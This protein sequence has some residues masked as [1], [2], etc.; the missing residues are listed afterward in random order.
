MRVPLTPD[1][2]WISYTTEDKVHLAGWIE[3]YGA[4]SNRLYINRGI[5][6]SVAPMRFN[7]PPELTVVTLKA[8]QP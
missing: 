7:A 8:G 5:G 4:P 1:W 6:F 2:T 3:G